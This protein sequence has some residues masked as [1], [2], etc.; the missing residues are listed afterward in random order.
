MFRATRHLA[1]LQQHKVSL[2]SQ[3]QI[4]LSKQSVPPALTKREEFPIFNERHR[5]G[6][7][8]DP[9]WEGCVRMTGIGPPSKKTVDPSLQDF[10]KVAH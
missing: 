3:T 1:L 7:S 9:A 4:G 5:T 8:R 2:Q 6:H 10:I